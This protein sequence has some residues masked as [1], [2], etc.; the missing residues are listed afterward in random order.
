MVDRPGRHGSPPD[1]E[2]LGVGW[3]RHFGLVAYVLTP[4]NLQ[5]SPDALCPDGYPV[6]GSTLAYFDRNP[7]HSTVPFCYWV[8]CLLFVMTSLLTLSNK[9]VTN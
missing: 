7:Y 9:R 1:E 5:G 6:T 4:H 2:R 3:K 8:R